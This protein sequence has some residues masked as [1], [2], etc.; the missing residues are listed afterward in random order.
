MKPSGALVLYDSKLMHNTIHDELA[1]DARRDLSPS[2]PASAA[3]LSAARWFDSHLLLSNN[4]SQCAS[5]DAK[6]PDDFAQMARLGILENGIKP[7]IDPIM[8][9][10]WIAKKLAGNAKRDAQNKRSKQRMIWSTMTNNRLSISNPWIRLALDAF[11]ATLDERDQQIWAMKLA[12][13]SQTTI[14]KSLG[15]S[16]AAISKRI[17]KWAPML[18]EWI[19]LQLSLLGPFDAR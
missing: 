18:T 17:A 8:H 2:M 6:S 11:A 10:Q 13:L 12:G 7:G 3:T 9:T 14:A 16:N 5:W 4:P 15:I 1:T 19:N